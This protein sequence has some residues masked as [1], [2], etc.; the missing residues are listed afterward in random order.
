MRLRH[1]ILV[2]F[3][4]FFWGFNWVIIKIGL[5][6]VSPLALCFARFF[7]ASL[8]AVFFIRRPQIPLKI[9]AVY[10]LVMFALQFALLFAGVYLGMTVGLAAIM[11]QQGQIFFTL[12]LVTIFCNERPNKWQ[13]IGILISWIGIGIIAVNLHASVSISGVLL[14]VASSAAWGVGNLISKKLQTTQMLPVIVWGSLFAWPP[15]LLLA[16]FTEGMDGFVNNFI[17]MSWVSFGAIIYLGYVATLF[18]FGVWS[19]LLNRYPA[20]TVVPFTLLIPIVAFLSSA[21]VLGEQI[22]SWEVLAGAIVIFGLC[23]SLV[24]SRLLERRV[25]S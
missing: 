18:G 10:G 11:S 7:F 22:K 20:A 2:L 15:M 24:F 13:I 1:L 6:G 19:F 12:L 14:V 8:P 5:G 3:L 21:I 25:K 9:L 16:V 17:H 4:I 23:F